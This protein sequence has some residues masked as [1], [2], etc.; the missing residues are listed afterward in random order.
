MDRMQLV[1]AVLRLVEVMFRMHH[2]RGST[3]RMLRGMKVA[4]QT[5]MI[6]CLTASG[7]RNTHFHHKGCVHFSRLCLEL[8]L[9]ICVHFNQ[10]ISFPIKPPTRYPACPFATNA[11]QFCRFSWRFTNAISCTAAKARNKHET[12]PSPGNSNRLAY[13]LIG[14]LCSGP[15]NCAC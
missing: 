3:A 9:D 1:P 10:F 8:S 4:H 13:S 2:L 7:R 12:A 14:M 6:C 5:C 15:L 11:L